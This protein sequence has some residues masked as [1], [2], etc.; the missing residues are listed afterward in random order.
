M[1]SDGQK[2]TWWFEAVLADGWQKPVK[3]RDRDN[4]QEPVVESFASTKGRSFY[5]T[6]G[7]QASF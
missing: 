6:G 3:R 2:W 1:L 5:E 7:W 4:N